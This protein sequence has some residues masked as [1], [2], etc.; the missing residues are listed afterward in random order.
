MLSASPV[1]RNSRIRIFILFLNLIFVFLSVVLLSSSCTKS[2]D[3]PQAFSVKDGTIDL[4][5][6]NPERD[7]AVPLKGEWKFFW[8]TLLPANEPLPEDGFILAPPTIWNGLQTVD[9]RENP[10]GQKFDGEGYASYAVTIRP[11]ASVAILAIKIPDAGSSMTVIANG[12]TV[13]TAG[14]VGTSEDSFT[15]YYRPGTVNLIVSPGKDIDLRFQVANFVDRHGG[16]Q[17]EVLIG[18]PA[19]IDAVVRRNIVYEMFLFGSILIIGFYHFG[20]YILRKQDSSP[21]WFG[22]FCIDIAL[23]TILMGERLFQTAFPGLPWIVTNRLE[24]FTGYLSIP[25]FLTFLYSL[26]PQEVK[27]RVV[28]AFWLIAAAFLAVVSF[29]HPTFYTESLPYYEVVIVAGIVLVVATM[30]LAARRRRPGAIQA[31]GGIL[32]L[33]GCVVLD[34]LRL[35]QIFTIELFTTLTPLGLFVFIL[36]KSYIISERFSRAYRTAEKLADEMKEL[37]SAYSKF[38]PEEFL[39]LLARGNITEIGLGDHRSM[40]MTVLFSD[41]RSFT[42][43]SESMTPEQ[44]FHFLNSLLGEAGPIIRKHD[45]FVDK[46]IG[47]SIMALFP[48][49]PDHA[50]DAAV[51]IQAK[52]RQFNQERIDAGLEPIDVGIGIHFGPMILG[53][54]GENERMQGT[55]ISDAVNLASRIEGLTRAYHSTI[56]ITGELLDRL[57]QRERFH[58]REIDIVRVKGKKNAVRLIEVLDGFSPAQRELHEKHADAFHRAIESFRSGD[59]TS[60]QAQFETIL[61]D[62]PDDGVARIYSRRCQRLV[63]KGI[64]ENWEGITELRYK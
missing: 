17:G 50:L 43:L 48:G 42:E 61:S 11:P 8:K 10:E 57:E 45:G 46:Y 56:L 9:T 20:L 23:R 21:F 39:R 62:D 27:L 55:V 15:P 19:Q 1:Y 5:E 26:Y 30:G 33:G 59:F 47:D 53:T 51:E 40:E 34:L 52:V 64:P 60:A 58:F 16:I 25:L 54:I 2:G 13:Y 37:N 29:T 28:Q 35:E 36:S 24:F 63:E 7:G 49:S 38:F 4:T 41:I 44:N 6:W 3:A 18:T 22:L 12:E 31:L 14:R 32:F